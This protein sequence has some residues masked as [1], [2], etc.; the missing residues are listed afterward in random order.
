MV[1][2]Q[3][4]WLVI[5]MSMVSGCRL[6]DKVAQPTARVVGVRLVDRTPDGI[7][8]E[9]DVIVE[10]PN[11]VALPLVRCDYAVTLDGMDRYTFVDELHRTLPGGVEQG[12]SRVGRQV[13]SLPVAIPYSG[14]DQLRGIR[15]RVQGV[16]YYQPPGEL[17]KL[18][19]ELHTDLPSVT[20]Q[21][22]GQID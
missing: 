8:L 6:V 3:F 1:T 12:G 2:R 5:A 16:L 17:L 14:T 18:L 15:Y 21:G 7:R 20:L 9:I 10:N 4:V 11:L 13:V 22:T 19:D